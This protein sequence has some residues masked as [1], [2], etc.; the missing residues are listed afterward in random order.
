MAGL[1]RVGSSQQEIAPAKQQ[2][3]SLGR[4]LR[5]QSAGSVPGGCYEP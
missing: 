3:L 2:P 5:P 4:S 1:P